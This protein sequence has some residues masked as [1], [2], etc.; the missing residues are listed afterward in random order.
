MSGLT[1]VL[2]NIRLRLAQ[3]GEYFRDMVVS[4][5]H[6]AYLTRHRIDAIVMRVRLVSAAFSG[7]TLLWIA[8]DA[9]TLPWPAW[10]VLAA[11]RLAAAAVFITLAVMPVKPKTLTGALGL[12]ALVLINPLAFYMAAQILFISGMDSPMAMVN[13]RLYEALPFI[14]MAGLGVFP[15][16]VAEGVVF[17]A[18]VLAVASLTPMMVGRG[19]WVTQITTLWILGL[20]LGIY[21]LAGMIQMHYMMALLRR[22]SHDLL[23]G[24]FSRRSGMELLELQF[25]MAH[26]RNAPFALAFV[27]V[28]NFKSVNDTFGHDVGDQVLRGVAEA[29]AKSLRRGDSV[30]RWGGEEFVVL[31][32]DADL[33]GLRIAMTRV[34][35]DW[36]GLRPDGLPVTASIGVAE[37]LMDG[38]EDWPDLVD[39]ADHRMY[40]AKT[41]GKAHVILPGGE[42][43]RPKISA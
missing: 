36:L 42:R 12:L 9:L 39:K 10:G 30:V 38:C 7:L 22:A 27:D 24:A 5:G 31:L 8:L 34:V 1:S 17:A 23:T 25:R 6:A 40:E 26:E 35:D 21:L 14:I 28:D 19:D 43:I 13:A 33:E 15:L 32:L 11:L 37:R 3:G 41:S 4:G 18:P 20:I 29:L 2:R 16:V